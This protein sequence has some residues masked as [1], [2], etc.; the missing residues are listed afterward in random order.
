MFASSH[1]R[2]EVSLPLPAKE[3]AM[4]VV[5]SRPPALI[6]GARA[7]GVPDCFDFFER[8]STN[9]RG[10]SPTESALEESAAR[11]S[12]QRACMSPGGYSMSADA[13]AGGQG[14]DD[15]LESAPRRRVTS[16]RALLAGRRAPQGSRPSEGG[17]VMLAVVEPV[18][19]EKEES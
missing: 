19:E 5:R 8:A 1:L 11:A 15:E 2:G 4:G 9:H 7:P 14:D 16:A 12:L 6:P 18:R 17:T 3:A 13:A 10:M